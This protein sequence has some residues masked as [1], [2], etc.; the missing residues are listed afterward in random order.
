MVILPLFAAKMFCT[1][2]ELPKICSPHTAWAN[3]DIN[4]LLMLLALNFRL[5]FNSLVP[6]GNWTSSWP[7]TTFPRAKSQPP[8]L[9]P[10]MVK[11]VFAPSPPTAYAV[12]EVHHTPDPQIIA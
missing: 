11:E 3:K 2:R 4:S 12:Q 6:R 1:F 9:L 7:Y 5:A 8:D 10:D